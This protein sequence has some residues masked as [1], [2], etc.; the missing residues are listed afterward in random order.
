MRN[1]SER[2]DLV[3]KEFNGGKLLDVGCGT[4]ELTRQIRKAFPNAEIWGCD[5]SNKAIDYCRQQ[6]RTIFYANH[7]LLNKEYEKKYF[8]MITI[9]HV[10]EHLE[11]PEE[12]IE[13]AKELL[14]KDGKLVIAVPINDNEWKE[15]LK[16]WQMEDVLKLLSKFDCEYDIH[17]TLS[18]TRKY[19]DGRPFE[20]AIIVIK[21]REV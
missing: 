20:Q 12:L 13:R 10:L 2:T 6:N 4:G 21:F 8:D 19:S 17:R 18:K 16:I 15:H 1:D 14:K 11:K 5:F 9:M 3:I 7:P